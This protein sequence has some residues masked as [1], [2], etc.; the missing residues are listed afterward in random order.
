MGKQRFRG[1]SGLGIRVLGLGLRGSGFRVS[2]FGLRLQDV[3]VF[4]K[5]L[6][7]SGGL[8]CMRAYGGFTGS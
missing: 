2:S 7:L 5:P 8:R 4:K 1:L 3:K 6:F